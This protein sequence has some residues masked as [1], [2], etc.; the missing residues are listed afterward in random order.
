M[1]YPVPPKAEWGGKRV[2]RESEGEPT[3]GEPERKRGG[4]RELMSGE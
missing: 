3:P 2:P 4:S 1:G